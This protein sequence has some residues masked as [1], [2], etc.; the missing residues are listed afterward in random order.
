L[1][2]E[3]RT[4]SGESPSPDLGDPGSRL[5]GLITRRH[6]SVHLVRRDGRPSARGGLRR[7]R[8]ESTTSSPRRCLR[9]GRGPRAL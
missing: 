3:D 9:V 2:G 5:K 8:R 1:G 7:G 6:V 4:D